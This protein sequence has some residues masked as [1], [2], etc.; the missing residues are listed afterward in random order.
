[1]IIKADRHDIKILEEEKINEKEFNIQEIKFEF[2]EDY[3]DFTRFFLITD[4]NDKTFKYIIPSNDKIS[5][6]FFEKEGKYVLGVYAEK[7]IEDKIYRL[8]PSP[9]IKKVVEG[10]FKE[11][12]NHKEITPNE[13]EQFI[14][15]LSKGI[16][17]I[18]NLIEKELEKINFDEDYVKKEENKGLSTNDF[19]NEYKEKV[20]SLQNFDDSEIK[21][22]LTALSEE[23]ENI[24][25]T[26]GPKG[27]SFTY[28]DFTEEQLSSLKGQNG[29]T[30][31]K[32]IDY[33]TE[34]DINSIKQ[35]CNNYI[36]ENYLS[37]L[38]EV[39]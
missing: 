29:Y 34:E 24:S 21:Q 4:L 6:P 39:Y 16:E 23:I 7:I 13:F 19:T 37:L 15:L 33:W 35:H 9:L 14:S 1:M 28:E 5:M 3:K 26:P 11:S 8:N 18:P 27:D 30:P 38:Q 17:N 36:D 31:Q 20:D 2:S 22:N 10:S 32:N 25:L 12:E